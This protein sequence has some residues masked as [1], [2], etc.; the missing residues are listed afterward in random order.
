M[1]APGLLLLLLFLALDGITSPMQEKLFQE[2]GLSKSLRRSGMICNFDKKS[3]SHVTYGSIMFNIVYDKSKKFYLI[4][5]L[6]RTNKLIFEGFAPH[7]RIGCDVFRWTCSPAPGTTRSCGLICAQP[8][9]PWSPCWVP[10]SKKSFQIIRRGKASSDLLS[11]LRLV[12]HE[13]TIRALCLR[14]V[15]SSIYQ[16]Y[17]LNSVDISGQKVVWK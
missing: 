11:S 14:R 16:I 6:L 1:W 12:K 5:P 8:S 15:R 10:A 17:Q 2:Y 4:F 9:C 7:C 3:V 13:R